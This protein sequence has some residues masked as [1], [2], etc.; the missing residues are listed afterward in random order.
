MC[1]IKA[2]TDFVNSVAIATK[3]SV[4]G[5]ESTSFRAS[6]VRDHGFIPRHGLRSRM[7]DAWMWSNI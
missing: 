4:R 6:G 7:W 1:L 3:L 2:G 5:G